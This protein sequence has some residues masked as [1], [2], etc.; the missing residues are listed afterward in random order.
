MSYRVVLPRKVGRALA[1]LPANDASRIAKI[2]DAMAGEPRPPG[3][4]KL[5]NSPTWRLRVGEYRIL[6]VIFDRQQLIAVEKV[7]RRT[8]TT[9]D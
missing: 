1:R 6:Y 3:V 9:Y 2:L 8:T 4:K 7:E 5:I